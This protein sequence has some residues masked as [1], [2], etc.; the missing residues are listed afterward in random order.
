M[1]IYSFFSSPR[2]AFILFLMFLI[3]YI[4]FLDVE[5]GFSNNFL[6]FGPSTTNPTY[7]LGVKLDSWSKVIIM[8]FIGFISALMTSYYYTIM[9]TSVHNYIYSASVK[10]VPHSKSLMYS[11]VLLE[12]ILYQILTVIQFFMNLTMQLQFILPQIIGDFVAGLPFTIN[13]LGTKQYK[14]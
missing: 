7:F 12:P 5:G 4:I 10:E 6:K 9:A 13:L 1:N 3:G 2:T 11:I 14:I 8:Y